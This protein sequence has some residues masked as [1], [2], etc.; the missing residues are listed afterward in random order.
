M[1]SHLILASVIYLLSAAYASAQT[2]NDLRGVGLVDL[3][4]AGGC[5]GT[6]IAPDTV[7]TAAHCLLSK[8]D[9][10][11]ISVENITFHPS[12]LNGIPGPGFSGRSISIH[13]VYLLPWVPQMRRVSRD[14][15]LLH[16]QEPVPESIATPVNHQTSG[17]FFGSGRIVSF[18]GRDSRQARH[19]DCD[20]IPTEFQVIQLSC[21]VKTGESGSP[22]LTFENGRPQLVG[23]ISSRSEIDGLPIALAVDLSV[24]LA[25]LLEVDAAK[26]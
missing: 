23:V 5:T 25:G 8:K 12:N 15:G 7:L 13:P 14:L 17:E 26:N 4:S 22:F 20:V 18:R 10:E 24:A 1:S 11:V 21:D 9:G 6:L 2:N 19:R 16:L 3:G